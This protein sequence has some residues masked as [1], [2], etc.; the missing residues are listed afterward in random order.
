MKR[1]SLEK[2]TRFKDNVYSA[3]RQNLVI[4]EPLAIHVNGSPYSVVMRTPGHEIFHAAGFCLTEGLVESKEDIACIGWCEEMDPNIITVTLTKQRRE[5]VREL[6]KRRGFISQTSCGI[7]GKELIK[8]LDK[9]L[10]PVKSTATIDAVSALGF[11]NTLCEH[12]DLFGKTY[13]THAAVL[14]DDKLN[15]TGAAED[16]GRHNALD[17]AIGSVLMNGVIGDSVLAVLS[18]RL[19][20]ELVQ[21]GIR[22]GIEIIIAISQPT[23]LAV[24]LAKSMNVSIARIR[25]DELIIF[26][27]NDRFI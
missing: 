8:D 26:S 9:V 22:A 11:E 2:I 27:G 10:S 1:L 15:V 17:K 4:E 13:S 24:T 25:K 5:K 14:L 23:E 18:S 19:S 7:C 21:K 20:Y 16:V 6:L 12:Q 3:D